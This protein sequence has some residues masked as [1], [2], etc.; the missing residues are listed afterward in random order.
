V[1]KPCWI[2]SYLFVLCSV[3]NTASD[4]DE[5]VKG[6]SRGAQLAVKEK[7]KAASMPHPPHGVTQEID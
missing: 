7:R 6:D 4:L 1:Q 2:A 5:R 3:V